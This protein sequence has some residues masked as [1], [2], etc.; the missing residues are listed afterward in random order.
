V[1]SPEYDRRELGYVS[2]YTEMLDDI[3]NLL[4]K[5]RATQ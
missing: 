1:N 5:C 4:I 3:K 2:G